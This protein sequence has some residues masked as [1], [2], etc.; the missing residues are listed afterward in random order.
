MPVSTS[1]KTSVGTSPT[2]L[3]ATWIASATRESSPPDATLEIARDAGVQLDVRAVPHA[4]A[5]HADEMWLSSS[6]K[7]VL[8][9]TTVDGRPY[10]SGRPGPVFRRVWEAFQRAKAAAPMP[11]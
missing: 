9:V 6:T 3:A 10:G 2:S 1:S 11:A 7:E 8:A 4:E 5:M